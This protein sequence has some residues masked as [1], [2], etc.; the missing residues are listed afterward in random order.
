MDKKAFALIFSMIVVVVLAVLGIAM[1]SRSISESRMAQRQLESVQ[2]FW[3]AEAGVNRALE[4]LRSSYNQAGQDLWPS[5][6]V[7]GGYSIDVAYS[8]GKTLN[9][10][11][12]D[13][14]VTVSGFFPADAPTMTRMVEVVMSKTVSS[15]FYDNAIYSVGDINLQGNAYSVLGDIVCGGTIDNPDNIVGTITFDPG[16]APLERLDFETLLAKSR[17]QNTDL[18]PGSGNVYDVAANGKL[19]DPETQIEKSLPGEFWYTRADDEVDNDGDGE[20][21]EEDEW[22]PN[23]CY[24]NG[25]L[26]L[27]GQIEAGGFLVVVGDVITSPDDVYDSTI[28]GTGHV[29]GAIYTRGNFIINGGGGE[30]LNINGGVWAGEETT[31]NGGVNAA[32]NEEY[33]M[34]IRDLNVAGITQVISWQ[35]LQ[36][37]YNLD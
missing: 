1:I 25:D 15:D 2:A 11:G 9:P 36:S 24:I 13:R 26:V 37:P 5:N 20:T 27:K 16:I 31:F 3:A 35:D 4:E 14:L 19:V 18:Y 6:L 34:A 33:M 29:E 7:E 17:A 30:G 32:Y 10:G 21:D 8:E 23:I 12:S 22:V 28:N